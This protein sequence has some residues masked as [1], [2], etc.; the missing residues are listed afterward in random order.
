[1]PLAPWTRRSFTFSA[2]AET[3]GAEALEGELDARSGWRLAVLEEMDTASMRVAVV[4]TNSRILRLGSLLM[5]FVSGPRS[6]CCR[7]AQRHVEGK[8]A[9]L[10]NAGCTREHPV[11][12][13]E[14]CTLDSRCGGGRFGDIVDDPW[15]EGV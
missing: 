11:T 14:M 5:M 6:T 10:L 3:L 9:R 4:L 15:E 1:M 12:T 13:L 2:E 7:H 8:G